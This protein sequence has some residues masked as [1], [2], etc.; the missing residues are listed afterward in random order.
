MAVAH[1]QMQQQQQQPMIMQMPPMMMPINQLQY[2]IPPQMYQQMMQQPPQQIISQPMQNKEETKENNKD[3]INTNGT[4]DMKDEKEV[5][6]E[7]NSLRPTY[8]DVNKI[9]Q[10]LDE[11]KSDN[12]MQNSQF[13][14]FLKNIKNKPPIA[15]QPNMDQSQLWANQFQGWN[16]PN[17][18]DN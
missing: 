7:L 14:N 16:D 1:Q 2:Q 4:Q 12:K 5:E 3:A 11:T 6:D 13:M 9:N 8:N 18:V 10:L 17:A 15:D